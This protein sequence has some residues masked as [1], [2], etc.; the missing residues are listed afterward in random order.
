[1]K[2]LTI[3]TTATDTPMGAQAYQEHVIARAHNAL[4][5]VDDDDWSLRR[6]IVRSIRSPLP[7]NRRIPVAAVSNAGVRS[8]RAVGRLLYHRST[9]VHRMSLELPPSP[10][11]NVV[12]L[13]DVVAWRFPDESAPIP[14]A[15]QELLDADAVICVSNFTAGE[16][17][18]LLGLGGAHVVHNGVDDRFFDAC[19]LDAQ[20]SARLGMPAEYVLHAGGA[21]TRKNLDALAEAWPRIRRERP[22]LQLLLVGPKHQRR[23]DLFKGMPGAM[24]AGMLSDEVL[25]AIVAGAQAVIVPS[26]Y[27]GFGLPALEAMA[28]NTPVVAATAGALP[29]VVGNT[30]ILVPPTAD[31]I[32]DGLLT[33]TSG[34]PAVGHLVRSARERAALFTWDRCALEHARIWKSLG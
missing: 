14:A 31:G 15:R 30:G 6:T 23:D 27:E 11:A 1:M 32:T 26:L 13:H 20:A 16:A 4:R 19:P 25:P 10:H 34:D 33:A 22:H 21:A 18:D 24:I 7:G 28:A 12:T 9:V 17:S 8:R 2:R 29:E 5:S 3:A